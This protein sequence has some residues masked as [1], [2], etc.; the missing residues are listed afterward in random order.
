MALI[1]WF[2]IVLDLHPS[3]VNAF[4]NVFNCKFNSFSSEQIRL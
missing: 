1:I 2:M 4:S 3:A